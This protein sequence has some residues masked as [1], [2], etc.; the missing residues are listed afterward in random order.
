MSYC[1]NPECSKP[2]N[3]EL[4]HVC[5]NCGSPLVLRNR[6]RATQS[7]G[8]G[9]FGRTYKAIDLDRLNS[10]CVIKQFLPKLQDRKAIEK[11]TEL[12]NQEA[13][14]LYELG[15]HPQIPSLLAFFVEA[16]RQYL[17]Q[18]FIPGKNLLKELEL[19]GAFGEA[20][21]WT[22]W[23]DI[24]PVL[25]F[26]HERQVIHRDIK[27][28]NIIRR[29]SDQRLVLIDF[30][31]AKVLDQAARNASGTT[32]GSPG[33]MPME[34]LVDGKVYP[35]SDLYG[36]GITS[37]HLLTM[38]S[39]QK[40]FIKYGFSWLTKWRKCLKQ[41]VSG[42]FAEVLDRL[43]RE[44]YTRRYQ[45]AAEVIL[46]I[47]RLAEGRPQSHSE[48]NRIGRS[49]E[50]QAV[51][52]PAVQPDQDQEFIEEFLRDLHQPAKLETAIAADDTEGVIDQILMDIQSAV[53]YIESDPS[54][55][56]QTDH[57]VA[58]ALADEVIEQFLKDIKATSVSLASFLDDKVKVAG[59]LDQT[60]LQEW[61]CLHT[62]QGHSTGVGN[63]VFA[64]DRKTLISA[65]EKRS[66]KSWDYLEGKLRKIMI[67]ADTCATCS[68]SGKIQQVTRMLVVETVQNTT[69]PDCAGFGKNPEHSERF[70]ATAFSNGGTHLAIATPDQK[71]K[72]FELPSGRLMRY[73]SEPLGQVSTLAFSPNR[74]ILAIG[75]DR[76]IKIWQLDKERPSLQLS[77]HQG[78]ILDLVIGFDNQTLI[79]AS[80]DKTIKVWNLK[81]GQIIRTLV[82]HQKGVT[83]LAFNQDGSQLASG[84]YDRMV[85][86]WHWQTGKHLLNLEGHSSDISALSFSS[87]GLPLLASGSSDGAINVWHLGRN[88]LVNI[89]VEHTQ[90]I[91]SLCFS[92]TG[93]HLVS[94]S[95]DQTLKIW[96]VF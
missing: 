66:V 96:R 46:D 36:L 54:Q 52:T 32:I 38:V 85:K 24:L 77:G 16:D 13:I 6:Y 45:S 25:Q 86:I 29:E 79:S 74:Q 75:S 19:E 71:I 39:P 41:P 65:G 31:V 94:G 68:G 81:T 76:L 80:T 34:L 56:I 61:A 10:V 84:S 53:T 91:K 92:P 11:A 12:F 67:D 8:Q 33:Y 90:P 63:L 5:Q 18:E 51:L 89:L 55:A 88:Q 42:V 27:P 49:L 40:L 7:L 15:E 20:K 72:L 48:S 58:D 30:G 37:F 62:L 43:L 60:N 64:S 2:Q 4:D 73:C 17:V 21:I 70:V 78:N 87:D 14:R 59:D 50:L 44:D 26:V 47:Q 22:L 57:E 35:A 93:Q 28:E 69:C 83:T 9:G 1:L 3:S 95:Q 23:R 82:G